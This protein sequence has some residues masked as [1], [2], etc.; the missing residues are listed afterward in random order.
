M[1][2]S[3]VMF[4]EHDEFAWATVGKF[5]KDTRTH[6]ASVVENKQVAGFK[7]IDEVCVF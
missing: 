3:A 1:V 7:E 6:D 4:F 5:G 2:D